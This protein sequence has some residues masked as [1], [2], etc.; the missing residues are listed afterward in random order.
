MDPESGLCRGCYR[1]LAEIA[2]W[3]ELSDAERAR[4]MAALPSRRVAIP[5][6]DHRR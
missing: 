2:R 4:V 5:Q 3:A 6:A 1:T